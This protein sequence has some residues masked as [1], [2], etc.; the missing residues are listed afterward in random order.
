MSYRQQVASQF[1]VPLANVNQV[2]A[3]SMAVVEFHNYNLLVS[4]RT[5]IGVQIQPNLNWLI[6]TKKYSPT[7][8][9]Q[10]SQF[11]NSTRYSVE[12]VTEAELQDKLTELRG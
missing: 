9:K 2:G 7:T 4:Y 3:K 1:N 6:T 11:I 8:S 10:T 5:I 12:R